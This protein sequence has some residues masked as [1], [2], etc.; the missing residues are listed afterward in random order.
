MNSNKLVLILNIVR[1]AL[2]VIGVGASLSLFFGPNVN[3]GTE[4][5]AAFRDGAQL[6]TAIMFTIVVL[7][8]TIVLIFLFFFLQLA[9]NPKKTIMSIIGIF[10]ALIIY[11]VFF[12]AGTSDTSD[13]LLLKNPVEDGTVLT[14]TAGLYTV[15]IGFAIGILVIVLGP[16]MGR[17]RK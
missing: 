5:V 13:S 14:T 8:A 1:I 10:A 17:Y 4:A 12:A 16:L 11:L 9:T 3:D 2:V 15:L 7:L 6:S